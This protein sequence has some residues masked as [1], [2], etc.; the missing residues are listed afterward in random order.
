MIFMEKM[1][2]IFKSN[3][4]NFFVIFSFILII[5]VMTSDGHRYS[6]DEDWA[7][8]Q[9]KRIATLTPHPLWVE[10]ETRP[11]YEHPQTY[12]PQFQT[13]AICNNF[14]LCSPATIGHSLTEVPFLLINENRKDIH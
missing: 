9:A 4:K 8:L 11:L 1:Q 6:S 3:T 7:Q 10:N 12:P 2:G 5:F 13:G 14:L